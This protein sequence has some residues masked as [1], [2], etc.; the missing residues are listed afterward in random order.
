MLRVQLQHAVEDADLVVA[1][2]L[3]ACAVELE[4]GLEFGLRDKGC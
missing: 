2:R 4:E 3:L 1:Q